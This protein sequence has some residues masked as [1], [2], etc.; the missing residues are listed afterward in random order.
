M[1]YKQLI[2][3]EFQFNKYIRGESTSAYKKYLKNQSKI[4]N[5]RVT[6]AKNITDPRLEAENIIR[7]KHMQF[8]ENKRALD[9][10]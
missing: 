6:L 4:G 10:D 7:Y 3:D 1:K 9:L 5:I 8:E 2:T